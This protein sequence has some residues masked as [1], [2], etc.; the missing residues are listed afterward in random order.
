MMT[1]RRQPDRTPKPPRKAPADRRTK[2]DLPG[3][4]TLPFP[5]PVV[6]E[7]ALLFVAADS[8]L[9]SSMEMG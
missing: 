3:Q 4:L 9:A 1:S 2:H 7:Q 6:P 8:D 5:A